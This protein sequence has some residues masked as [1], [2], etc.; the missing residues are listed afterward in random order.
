VA[1]DGGGEH[2]DW[3]V[4]TGEGE[5]WV[6]RSDDEPLEEEESSEPLDDESSEPLDVPVAEDE[7]LEDDEPL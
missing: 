5:L 1:L 2:Q 7:P 6:D 4:V 3:L